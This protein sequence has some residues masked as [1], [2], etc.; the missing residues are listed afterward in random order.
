VTAAQRF[1][2]ALAPTLS[3]GLGIYLP[4]L[5]VNC[6]LLGSSGIESWSHGALAAA[7]RGA[8]FAVVLVCLALIREVLGAGTITLFPVGRFAGVVSVRGL[9][10]ARVLAAAPGALLLLG[11][12]SALVRWRRGGRQ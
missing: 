8:A 4:L 9:A 6:L 3:A 10:P 11:Y 12:I 5:A 1:L 2:W 7:R